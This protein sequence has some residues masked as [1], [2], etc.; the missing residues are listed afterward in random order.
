MQG[1]INPMMHLSKNLED[2]FL[3]NSVNTNFNHA[4]IMEAKKKIKST[5]KY[6]VDEMS[7]KLMAIPNGLEPHNI[8]TSDFPKLLQALEN[9]TTLFLDKLIEEI[10]EKEE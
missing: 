6:H 1:H 9:S 5:L 7:I 3:I 4:R 10:N 2:G 8:Q